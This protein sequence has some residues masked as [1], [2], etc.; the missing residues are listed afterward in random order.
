MT[1]TSTKY[2][3]VQALRAIAALM[4]LLFH[5]KLVF[6]D[7]ETRESLV[8]IPGFTDFGDLG[9]NLFFVISGFIIATIVSRPEF[10]LREYFW[11][12]ILR[13][14]PL[15][16]IVMFVGICHYFLRNW[17]AWDLNEAGMKGMLLSAVA[18]PQ[19]ASPFWQPGWTL[20]HEVLF[21]FIAAGVA[22]FFGL[23]GLTIFLLVLGTL[24]ILFAFG[25]DYHITSNAQIY[26]AGGVIAYLSR[27]APLRWSVPVFVI[28]LGVY[29]LGLYGVIAI[30]NA[31]FG[32]YIF[33]VGTAAL[34][35]AVLSLERRGMPPPK[36]VVGLGDAS[37]SLYLW[38]WMLIPIVGVFRDNFGG[39]A[40]VWRWIFVVTAIAVALLSYQIIEKP[41]IAFS[42][43]YRQSRCTQ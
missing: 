32:H 2:D 5:S 27:N 41:I 9:V 39:G 31:T 22:P 21:Y 25:W 38:H 12:R 33:S 14:Y 40:E 26:F 42:H 35:V 34:I 37:Y 13:I 3:S 36:A 30:N 19:A 6:G 11:R 28:F 18:F 23:V 29:Y 24:G 10:R 15:L 7:R 17:F 43:R 16:W 4:V 20:E 8:R 1:E